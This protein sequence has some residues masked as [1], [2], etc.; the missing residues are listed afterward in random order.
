MGDVVNLRRKRKAQARTARADEA[1]QN[2]L[3]FGLSKAERDRMETQRDRI[4]KQH[5]AHRLPDADVP[6]R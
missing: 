5:E 6:H 3:T 1:A 2:R 4:D